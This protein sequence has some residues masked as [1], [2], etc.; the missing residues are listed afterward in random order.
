MDAHLC[1]LGLF[2]LVSRPTFNA[3]HFACFLSMTAILY[4]PF[5]CYTILPLCL[6]PSAYQTEGILS[7]SVPQCCPCDSFSHDDCKPAQARQQC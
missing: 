3:A 5:V 1:R 4:Y 6:L 2:L 7:E